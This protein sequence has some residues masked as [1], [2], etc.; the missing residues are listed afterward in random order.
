M[1]AVPRAD[2]W[3]RISGRSPGFTLLEVVVGVALLAG[4][5]AGSAVLISVANR[6]L[7]TS[8]THNNAQAAIDSDISRARKLAEDYTCCPGSC[9]T[10]ATTIAAARTTGRCAPN[11]QV[12]DS[13]YYFPQLETTTYPD[14]TGFTNACANGTLVGSATSGLIK[15]ISDQGSSALGDAGITRTVAVDDSTDPTAHR[16]RI[17]YT[18]SSSGGTTGINRVVKLVPTVAAWCP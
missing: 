2:G 5:A 1:Q 17:T 15:E 4:V 10:N 9:T 6:M 12:N 7:G 14:V 11:A 16:I 18:G 3:R 8:T 13:T